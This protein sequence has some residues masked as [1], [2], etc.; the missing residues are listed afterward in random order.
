MPLLASGEILYDL[1]F[2]NSWHVKS[3]KYNVALAI[4]PIVPI[5]TSF[6]EKPYQELGLE[7]LQQ[8]HWY[9]KPCFF[10]EKKWKTNLSS[11]S[12]NLYQLLDKCISQDIIAVFLYSML[13]MA[14]FKKFSFY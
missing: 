10:F 7:S 6:V 9:G 14:I 2:T 13:S 3:I 4:V 1:T 8:P 11:A 5:R 12:S